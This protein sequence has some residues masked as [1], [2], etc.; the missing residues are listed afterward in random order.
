MEEFN[1]LKKAKLL[2]LVNYYHL[3]ASSMPKL[4]I[5]QI[6]VTYLVDKDI[7]PS[8]EAMEEIV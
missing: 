1:S 4:Q 7:I 8:P 5:K 2:Q 3:T 6:T